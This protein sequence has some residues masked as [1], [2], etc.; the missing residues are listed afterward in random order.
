[1]ARV[2]ITNLFLLELAKK[3]AEYR[4][5]EGVS[6]E[7]TLGFIDGFKEACISLNINF[8]EKKED[9]NDKS[10]IHSTSMKFEKDSTTLTF[11]NKGFLPIYEI[12][13]E[14]KLMLKR[15]ESKIVL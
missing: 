6:H 1:M 13:K 14:F 2:D 10:N 8:S 7:M 9:C 3:V 11:S 12:D 5:K 4:F 15:L